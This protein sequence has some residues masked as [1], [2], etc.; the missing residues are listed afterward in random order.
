MKAAIGGNAQA[1]YMLG[2]MYEDG[3]GVSR[4][5]QQA[6]LWFRIAAD[7]G[8]PPAQRGIGFLY[9]NGLGVTQD[10]NQALSWYRKAAAQLVAVLLLP[11][12]IRAA[13]L[14][15]DRHQS[16]KVALADEDKR[17]R[18]E[19]RYYDRDRKEYHT[20]DQREDS[21]YRRWMKEER[22]RSYRP[23]ET[24]NAKEQREYWKWRHEHPD[25]DRDRR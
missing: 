19:K 1:Q 12:E 16:R 22:H 15:Q 17:E 14:Q 6:M 7:Q 23:F 8:Y 25:H 20:W 24:L 4:D 18:N 5:Y 11:L 9:S 10:Y 13:N 3:Q 21:A 2:M